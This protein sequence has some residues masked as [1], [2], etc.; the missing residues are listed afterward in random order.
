MS[1]GAN[2]YLYERDISLIYAAPH[3]HLTSLV[4]GTKRVII[5]K[6]LESVGRDLINLRKNFQIN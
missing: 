5:P 4:P 1:L 2:D 6:T 3:L